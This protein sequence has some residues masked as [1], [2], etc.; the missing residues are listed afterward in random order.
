MTALRWLI[1]AVAGLCVQCALAQDGRSDL[2]RLKALD[3]PER[4]GSIRLF[5]SPSAD[6]E[7]AIYGQALEQAVAWYRDK[8]GWTGDVIMAVLNPEDWA[9]VSQAIPYPSPY[10]DTPSGLVMM[11]DRIDSHPGFETWDLEP[12]GLNAA[13]TFHEIGHVIAHQLGIWSGNYWI[14]ELVANA[15]LAAYVRAER[16]EYAKLLDGVPPRFTDFGRYTA[17]TDF[18]DI[19]YAM[20]ALNYA[21]FQFKIAALADYLVSGSDFAEVVGA[22]KREF[23]IET[24][25]ELQSSPRR[26]S[27]LKASSRGS[28]RRA[29][30]L[31]GE[32]GLSSDPRRPAAR[33]RRQRPGRPDRHREPGRRPRLLQHDGDDPVR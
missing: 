23:P 22:L 11:P 16:P 18:D 17:L 27:G 6:A 2:D 31:L 1:G 3:L 4:A 15:F 8:T 28:P 5:Y 7:A 21:W 26:S 30:D 25:D 33:N 13:L 32:S 24:A 12:V 14:N 20:G 19:Y 29:S 9:K 10:A